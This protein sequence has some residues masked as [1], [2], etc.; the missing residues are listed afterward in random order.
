MN[1]GSQ[2]GTL[3]LTGTTPFS[4]S[5]SGTNT[6]NLNGTGSTVNYSGTGGQ[7]IYATSYNNLT[8]SGSGSK[9]LGTGTI[10]IG[11]NLTASGG[12]MAGGTSTTIFTGTASQ[13][14]G[15]NAK[16][17]NHL[18][19]N[20]GASVSHTAASMQ[21][22][23][24]FSNSGTFTQNSGLTTAFGGVTQALSGTVGN[25]TTFGSVTVQ[26][27]STLSAGSQN[28]TV[29]GT[30]NASSPAGVFNGGTGTVTFSGATAMGDN[31]G[32]YNFNNI[33]ISTG[34]LSNA[35]NKSFT[36]GGNWT[37]NS[38]YAKGEE[39]ITF[40]SSA[41][42]TIGGSG[43]ETPFYNV[44]F[45]G[46]GTKT[47]SGTG[48][49]ISN[50]AVISTGNVVNANA[51]LTLISTATRNANLFGPTDGSSAYITG[52]VKVQS[53]L[54]GGTG[55]RRYKFVSSPI[56][57]AV[58]NGLSKKTYA[59]I[60]NSIYVT[61]ASGTGFDS[62]TTTNTI[63]TYDETLSPAVYSYKGITNITD[64][65]TPG[66]GFVVFFRGNR[67]SG[68]LTNSSPENV[69]LA[70]QGT[71]NQGPVTVSNLK[72][73]DY[74]SYVYPNSTFIKSDGLNLVGNPYPCTIDFNLIDTLDRKNINKTVYVG[75][76]GSSGFSGIV[77]GATFNSGTSYIQ[78]GQSFF[79]QAT[80]NNSSITFRESC[81]YTGT[82]Q[83]MRLLSTPQS[84][85]NRQSTSSAANQL[86]KLLRINLQDALNI[87]ET[88][89]EFKEKNKTVF[90]LSEDASY[91]GGSTVSLNSVA[92]SGD[93]LLY[94]GMPAIRELND[95]KLQINAS[96]SGNVKLNFT[97]LSAIGN[98]Q[99]FLK[100]SYLN[101]VVDVKAN[102]TYAFVIDKKIPAT[103]GATRFT[104]QFKEPIPVKISEFNALKVQS[105]SEISWT[106]ENEFN[107]ERFE[108]ERST[109]KIIFTA[110]ANISKQASAKG[111]SN[112]AYTDNSPESGLNYYRLKQV[113]LEGKLT[114]TDTLSVLHGR[115]VVAVAET[116]LKLSI[117]PNPT[118]DKLVVNL[119]DGSDQDGVTMSVYDMQGNKVKSTRYEHKKELEQNVSDLT[120]NI[121]LLEIRDSKTNQLI[122]TS[123]FLKQ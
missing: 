34:T 117:Y 30:F 112:Y 59:Q 103:F 55:T 6:L 27:T 8:L 4:L 115:M 47:F 89:I 20:S 65:V 74:S 88:L 37:N 113:D 79:V 92:T 107:T 26:G 114:Y 102:P 9:T 61:G 123:K 40:N 90:N 110:I 11:G 84:A 106:T 104:L 93:Q 119:P 99:M 54:T 86:P 67:S 68:S 95:I 75:K 58:T 42:Q 19:I 85:G 70:Y 39:T 62:G 60:Q 7:T 18:T 21:I 48:S 122:G 53:Y 69:T 25:S 36:V 77:K 109:D 49:S 41:A 56:N 116:Q 15:D 101:Q 31:A 17:F 66:V 108:V 46:G 43:T 78:P 3:S 111:A 96:V 52:D 22:N 28:F 35:N 81:K 72:F 23:G 2:N 76:P 94:N 73:T 24:D 51:K 57:D 33:I 16:N 82:L 121:Y 13:I 1:S 80:V 12:T 91:M 87:D 5:L 10:T 118:V 63:Q 64:V 120:A 45:Q 29:N 83:P 14:A 32:T 38:I 50:S 44:N 98:Y 97:D 100:D 71:V 105:K